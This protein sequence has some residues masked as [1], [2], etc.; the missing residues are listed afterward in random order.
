MKKEVITIK[1]LFEVCKKAIE[2][3]RGD[4]VVYIPEDVN[5]DGCYY[6]TPATA[7]DVKDKYIFIDFREQ[8]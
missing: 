3:G 4:D 6:L 2:D 7:I 1:D 5:Y 8:K